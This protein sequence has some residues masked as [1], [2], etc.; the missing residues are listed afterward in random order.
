MAKDT[1]ATVD[2][3]LSFVRDYYARIDNVRRDSLMYNEMMFIDPGS[4][5]FQDPSRYGYRLV[6]RT[7][8][9]HAEAFALPFFKHHLTYETATLS[10]DALFDLF[11]YVHDHMNTIYRDL[12]VLSP[13]HY[14]RVSLYNRLLRRYEA[15]YDAALTIGDPAARRREFLTLG[16]QFREELSSC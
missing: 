10:R 2:T 11:L 4:L 8:A 7:L 5:A 14:A 16:A 6:T 12:G 1:R 15:P 3:T 9:E 13:E